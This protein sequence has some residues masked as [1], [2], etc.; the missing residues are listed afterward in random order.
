MECAVR[1]VVYRGPDD[2]AVERVPRPRLAPGDALVR[3]AGCGLCGSDLLKIA[4][5]ARPPVALGHELSG[6]VVACDDP[7]FRVGQRVVV[8]HH[9]P[10]GTCHYCRAGSPTMCAAFRASG[11]DPCGFAEYVRVPAAQVAQVMLALP[12]RVTH[13][14][15]SFVEPLAC[16]LRAVGRA[17]AAGVARVAVLGL[18]SMG[19]LMLQAL[20]V[21]FPGAR[22]T[23]VD[24]LAD[25]RALALRL[26]AARTLAPE[27][28]VA[29]ALR[30]DS[31][32][33]GA[34][35]AVLTAAIPGALGQAHALV[36]DGGE[37]LLFA[38]GMAA[39]E[40]FATWGWYHRE[41]RLTASYSSTPADLRAALRLIATDRVRVA[42]LI[43]H[44]LPIEAFH[45]GVRLARSHQALKVYVALNP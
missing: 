22:L 15:A 34:D 7:R 2:V 33:R 27:D 28:D 25:R 18:G 23:G 6:T 14:Q 11:L 13:E 42:E 9:V 37:V 21:R 45:E 10:C 8:A 4:S 44:R 30:A 24:P 40:D 39:R 20:A 31:D 36:R 19:L 3:V 43:S 41:L 12:D 16:C 5:G 38:A 29:G 1:A 26:G 17:E 32:G 35:L